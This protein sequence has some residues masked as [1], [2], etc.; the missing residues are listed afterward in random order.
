MRDLAA[1]KFFSSNART[2]PGNPAWLVTLSLTQLVMD[3]RTC[4]VLSQEFYTYITNARILKGVQMCL[5]YATCLQVYIELPESKITN[6]DENDND[7]YLSL[8]L[9][10]LIFIATQMVSGSIILF[11]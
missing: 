2:V 5:K 10:Q 4:L 11:F 3:N 6:D 9:I 1:S 8:T 7:T